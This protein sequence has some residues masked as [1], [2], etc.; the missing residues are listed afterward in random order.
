MMLFLHHRIISDTSSNDEINRGASPAPNRMAI[1]SAKDVQASKLTFL[2]GGWVST[3]SKKR[4]AQVK[5]GSSPIW[6]GG[7]SKVKYL[8]NHQLRWDSLSSKVID[9]TSSISPKK[10]GGFGHLLHGIL[11]SVYMDFLTLPLWIFSLEWLKQWWRLGLSRFWKLCHSSLCCRPAKPFRNPA[12]GTPGRFWPPPCR[13]TA[14]GHGERVQPHRWKKPRTEESARRRDQKD[15]TATTLRRLPRIHNPKNDKSHCLVVFVFPVN[16]KWSPMMWLHWKLKWSTS[17][18]VMYDYSMKMP[19]K[20]LRCKEALKTSVLEYEGLRPGTT[21][22][23]AAPQRLCCHNH[24]VQMI[25]CN[26]NVTFFCSS[27]LRTF[28]ETW[29][30]STSKKQVSSQTQSTRFLHKKKTCLTTPLPIWPMHALSQLWKVNVK[31][32]AGSFPSNPSSVSR[33]LGGG[34][35]KKNHV[36]PTNN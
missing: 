8:S 19:W 31:P 11:V 18:N 35:V 21:S 16:F 29:N 4:Y 12:P 36:S 34:G 22:R 28:H 9:E 1:G 13:A 3:H 14:P 32:G 26:V 17:H 6:I 7:K 15:P 33:K 20:N 10:T 5:F 24:D 2:V 23:Q 25:N 30:A 27:F